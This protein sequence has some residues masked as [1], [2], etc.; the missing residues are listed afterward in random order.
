MISQKVLT[1]Y[2]EHNMNVLL[3]GRHGVGKTALIHKTF[4]DAGY[5]Y[6]YFSAS[7]LDPWVDV[8]GIPSRTKSPTGD[9]VEL[10][11]PKFVLDDDV[12]A[13]FFDELN[14]ADKKVLNAVMELIQFK[15][16]N[17]RKLNKLKI[18]WG[19]INPP[20]EDETYA[21][22]EMDPA[23]L[24]RFP[25]T[26]KVPYE[27]DIKYFQKYGKIGTIFCDWWN[28]LPDEVKDD[29]SPRRLEYALN[30]YEKNL[31]L[32]HILPKKSN[33]NKLKSALETVSYGDKMVELM[34]DRVAAAKALKNPNFV[35][36]ILSKK[37]SGPEKVFMNSMKLVFQKIQFKQL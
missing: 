24:D 3:E 29:V 25:V 6:L 17:G 22:T 19:A 10:I 15:S 12:D 37:D 28:A 13:I 16:I 36:H 20:D 32:M 27:P 7:T 4:T 34:I 5:K 14:R 30:A 8:V 1:Q 11:P 21:V 2:L 26:I 35:D 23:Q 9:Y 18:V 31:P 33:I